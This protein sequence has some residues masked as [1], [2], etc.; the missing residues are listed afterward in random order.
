MKSDI[1]WTAL[2]ELSFRSS[3]PGVDPGSIPELE[4]KIIAHTLSELLTR[5]DW[6]GVLQLRR[7]FTDLYANDSMTGLPVL[8]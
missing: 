4:W 6:N 2:Q 3:A 1:E 7:T 5:K 8:Q